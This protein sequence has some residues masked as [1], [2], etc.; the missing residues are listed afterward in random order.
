MPFIGLI[1]VFLAGGLTGAFRYADAFWLYR[2][3]P[4]PTLT[5]AARDIGSHVIDPASVPKSTLERIFVTSSAIHRRQPVWV[6]LPAGYAEHPTERYPVMYFLHGFP[7]SPLAYVSVGRVNFIQDI[8][9]AD[10]QTSPMIQVMPFGSTTLFKD[11][12]WANGL[13]PGSAWETFVARDVVNAIDSRFRTIPSGSG[14]AIAG[15]S[16]GAYGAL[17]IGLHHPGEFRV[18]ESWS[19]YLWA[20]PIQRIFGGDRGLLAYNSPMDRVRVVAQALRDSHTYI[21]FYSGTQDHLV[22]MNKVF[23][24]ELNRLKIDHLF[25]ASS[26]SHTWRLWRR[27]VPQ[28]LIVASRHM[29]KTWRG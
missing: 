24:I 11:N 2:G 29:S 22:R 18:I 19:G 23:D 1:A 17:N 21:W 8:L 9:V 26:G 4:P 12:E 5:Q 10:H 16:E 6:V 13:T 20:D 25:F 15:L 28:A 14:R 3:F 27:F 7:G